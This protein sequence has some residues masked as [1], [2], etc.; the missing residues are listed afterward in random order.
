MIYHETQSSRVVLS[1]S[2]L[3][4]YLMRGWSTTRVSYSE[5]KDLK[6][7]IE[8]A[9]EELRLMEMKLAAIEGVNAVKIELPI[10]EKPTEEEAQ[11]PLFTKKKGRPRG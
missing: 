1:E 8:K 4:E 5:A 6:A 11:I 3:K 10:V 9:K 2:E 7:K